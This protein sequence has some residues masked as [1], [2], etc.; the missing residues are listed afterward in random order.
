MR[1]IESD[2]ASE[3]LLWTPLAGNHSWAEGMAGPII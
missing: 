3:C 2:G 1:R